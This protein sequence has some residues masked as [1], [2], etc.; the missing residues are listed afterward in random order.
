MLL[1]FKVTSYWRYFSIF[2]PFCT[3]LMWIGNRFCKDRETSAATDSTENFINNWLIFLKKM[4]AKNSLHLHRSG[5][6]LYSFR[7]LSS[8]FTSLG[9][10]ERFQFLSMLIFRSP[11]RELS[12][13]SYLV[14]RRWC[15]ILST[16]MCR[17]EHVMCIGN[18]LDPIN[19]NNLFT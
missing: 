9:R 1:H 12:S 10:E 4:G 3:M 5:I 17:C 15:E 19:S 2:R 8:I 6:T 16:L 7:T 14:F 11:K 18:K 13:Y